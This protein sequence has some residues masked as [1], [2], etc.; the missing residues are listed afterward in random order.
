MQKLFSFRFKP[1]Y[2]WL[3]LDLGA[4]LGLGAGCHFFLQLSVLAQ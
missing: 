4:G 2:F 1:S 3:C